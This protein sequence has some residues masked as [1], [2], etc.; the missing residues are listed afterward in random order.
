M[1]T[2]TYPTGAIHHWGF[3]DGWFNPEHKYSNA[4]VKILKNIPANWT[5]E[6][7]IVAKMMAYIWSI[8]D[9]YQ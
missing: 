6:Q 5:A 3:P 9:E 7:K 1:F 8:R 2:M 4:V